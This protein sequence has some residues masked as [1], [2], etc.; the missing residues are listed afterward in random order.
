MEKWTGIDWLAGLLS[1]SRASEASKD[2]IYT[3]NSPHE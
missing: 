3:F 1:L 2:F